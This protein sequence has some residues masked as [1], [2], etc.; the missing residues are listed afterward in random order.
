MCT[1]GSPTAQAI[2]Q[3]GSQLT[4]LLLVFCLPTLAA[5]DHLPPLALPRALADALGPVLAAPASCSVLA[6][7]EKQPRH[8]QTCYLAAGCLWAAPL[9]VRPDPG[10]PLLK[11]LS[12]LQKPS[13]LCLGLCCPMRE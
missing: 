8:P 12:I 5:A 11:D 2:L 6:A 13:S 7:L 10:P 9:L 1:K 3:A 4:S